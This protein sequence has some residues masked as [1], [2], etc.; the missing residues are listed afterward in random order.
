[1]TVLF[2]R[3]NAVFYF[4]DHSVYITI[5]SVQ[6]NTA[7]QSLYAAV[8]WSIAKQIAVRSGTRERQYQYII[9]DPV[10]E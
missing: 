5:L 1:M 4:L 9:F 7:V 3:K 8:F 10:N 2:H 6:K